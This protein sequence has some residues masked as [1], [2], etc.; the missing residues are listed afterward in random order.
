MKVNGNRFRRKRFEHFLGLIRRA[1]Q[2]RQEIRILDIG[3]TRD[4]WVAL[5]DMWSRYPIS[6]TIV[7]MEGETGDDGPFQLRLGD[8]CNLSEYADNSFD[9][10]HSNSVIEKS[11]EHTSELQ[12][13]MRISYAVF[14]L[15]KK[16]NAQPTHLQI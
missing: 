1:A 3:G 11:E 15:K 7:N 9:I 10:V 12:S 5:Q 14:C 13:L 8:A 16:N 4:Y 6:V 2:S